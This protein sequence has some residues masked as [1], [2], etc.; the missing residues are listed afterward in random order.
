MNR[1]TPRMFLMAVHGA[2]TLGKPLPLRPSAFGVQVIPLAEVL[3]ESYEAQ[4]QYYSIKS[5]AVI[6]DVSKS[7][8]KREIRDKRL[9]AQKRG[10][11][12]VIAHED[13]MAYLASLRPVDAQLTLDDIATGAD[14]TQGE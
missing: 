12:T 8:V 4:R 11:R 14:Q 3:P 6:S 13:A 2:V 1:S 9:K 10:R 7:T 5:F